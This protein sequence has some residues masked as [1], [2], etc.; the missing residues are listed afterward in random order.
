MKLLSLQPGS[1]YTNGGAGR[2]LRRL[3]Y[4]HESSITSIY[5]SANGNRFPGLIKEIQINAWPLQKQWMRWKLRSFFTYLRDDVFKNRTLE[6]LK[7]QAKKIDFDILHVINHGPYSC[8]LIEPDLLKDKKLWVS[9]HDHYILCSTKKDCETLWHTADRRLVISKE[10]G[11]EYQKV[12]GKEEF[13]IITDGVYESEISTPSTINSKKVIQI[14]FG[15]LLH[16]SYLPL[17]KVLA[18]AL[19]KLSKTELKFKLVM[20]GTQKVKFLENRSFQVDFRQDFVNDARI[21]TE[22]DE[23]DIL[24]LP[25]KFNDPEFYLYS[26]S[27]KMIGYLGA[28]GALLYHGPKD[29]AAL[30][31]LLVDNCAISCTSLEVAEMVESIEHIIE[32]G[33]FYS[34]NAKKLAKDEFLINLIQKR[35]W[36]NEDHI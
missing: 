17:F 19:D 25:I 12:F 33:N 21:K 35:F 27:T 1:L 5:V 30:N 9:F 28:S 8:T 18:D 4:G 3:Y 13:E 15:G 14:Y 34:S 32:K 22:Q 36:Q 6:K 20:R 29:S 23:S 31:L 10:L 24:Y 11:Q 7:V 2:V 16:I 26:L